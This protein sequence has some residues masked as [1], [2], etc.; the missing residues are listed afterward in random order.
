MV[1]RELGRLQHFTTKVKDTVN[2]LLNPAHFLR[3][4][5]H[6]LLT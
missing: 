6:V 3:E 2:K 1:V 4:M 5:V